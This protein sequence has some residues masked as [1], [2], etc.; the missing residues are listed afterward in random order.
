VWELR[1]I[2]LF[3]EG[4][5]DWDVIILNREKSLFTTDNAVKKKV[6]GDA[7]TKRFFEIL[8]QIP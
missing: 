6:T 7:S 1:V 4:A 5:Y 3:D 2:T 8:P